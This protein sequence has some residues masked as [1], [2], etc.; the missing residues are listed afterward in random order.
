[1]LQQYYVLDFQDEDIPEEAKKEIKEFAFENEFS[2]DTYFDLWSQDSLFIET[3]GYLRD[4]YGIGRGHF[5][6]VKF[7]W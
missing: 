2:N 4:K 6:L 3:W 5:V 1:M 7:W